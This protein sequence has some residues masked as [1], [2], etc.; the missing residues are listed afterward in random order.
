MKLGPQKF[1]NNLHQ[2]DR[3]FLL[4]ILPVAFVFSN[5]MFQPWQDLKEIFLS[6]F[7]SDFKIKSIFCNI[8]INHIFGDFILEL[9]QLDIDF[10]FLSL[11]SPTIFGY[12]FWSHFSFSL[13]CFFKIITWPRIFHFGTTIYSKSFTN[14]FLCSWII[15]L[16]LF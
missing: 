6:C 13:L 16:F 12:L 15:K 14:N 5:S 9:I 2:C 4:S 7:I 10:D 8:A 1:I 11:I 3:Y